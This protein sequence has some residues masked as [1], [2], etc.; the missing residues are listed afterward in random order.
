[1][2]TINWKY[3]DN[4]SQ[5]GED[6]IIAIG[7]FDGVHL[8][9]ARL[10]EAAKLKAKENNLSFGVVT[11]SPHPREFFSSKNSSFKLLDD[12][13][14]KYQLSKLGVDYLI[15]IEFNEQLKNLSPNEFL[16][17]VLSKAFRVKK[18]F[19]GV[20]FKFGK[21]REGN[22]DIGKDLGKEIGLEV[23]G[24]DLV[25]VK[26]IKNSNDLQDEIISSQVI[27]SLIKAGELNG[28]KKLLGRNWCVTGTVILGKQKGRDL[29]FPTA[30][31]D[32]EYFLKPP[33][34]VYVTRLKV[35]TGTN[36]DKEIE[37][38]P[39]ISNIGTRP[40]VSGN[41][42]NI[43]THIIDF[44]NNNTDT[45]LYGKRVKVELLNFIREEK[46]FNSLNELKEQIAID[47]NKACEFHK[48]K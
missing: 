4:V 7:N 29:G 42:I 25:Q 45:N 33:L 14:K 13:E 28:V 1:M 46:K 8:G 37:W 18:M 19:A 32:M 3:G 43:E 16:S 44:K 36:I 35:I 17:N 23:F 20:N 5:I 24:I 31:V 40:T 27:R 2:K 26:K 9:H 10:L 38:L 15:I 21:N 47:T 30:N 11:F 39:S 22:I 41:S 6:I 12:Q 34:G 48:L